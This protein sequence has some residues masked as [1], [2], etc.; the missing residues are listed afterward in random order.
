[1]ILALVFLYTIAFFLLW[2]QLPG[3]PL[4]TNNRSA[5]YHFT[6]I[7]QV[8]FGLHTSQAELYRQALAYWGERGELT[9]LQWRLIVLWAVSGLPALWLGW[10]TFKAS[11]TPG[12]T[13][14]QVKGRRLLEGDEGFDELKAVHDA[15]IARTGRSSFILAARGNYNPSQDKPDSKD[16]ITLSDDARRTHFLVLGGSRRGKGVTIKQMMQQHY[17]KVRRKKLIKLLI[18]DTPK[19]EYASMFKKKYMLQIAPD[20]KF[21]VKY[22][23]SK[24]LSLVQDWQQF[25]AGLIEVS[26]KDPFWGQAARGVVT[27]IGAFLIKECGEDWSFNNLAYFKD[28][29]APF[30]AHV[31]RKYYP[32]IQTIM[33]MGEAPLS[34]VLGNLTASLVW[35]N[36]LAR[37]WDGYEYKKE[38]HQLNAKMLRRDF[39]LDYMLDSMFPID[40]EQESV[41]DEV[42][43]HTKSMLT[44]LV[45][46][47]NKTKKVWTWKDLK[48]LL[49]MPFSAQSQIAKQ[50]LSSRQKDFI[51]PSHLPMY[52]VHIK[53]F[54]QWAEVWDKYENMPSFSLNEWVKDEN[55]SKK[56]VI[57]KPSGRFREQTV[58]L[59]RGMLFYMQGIINDKYFPEDKTAALPKREFYIVADEFQALGNLREFF[60][61]GMEM[62]ASKGVTLLLACQDFSQLQAIY[63][64]EWLNFLKTNTGNIIIA[65]MNQG[66][67]A[68]MV[69]TQLLG[70]KSIVKEHVTHSEG[71]DGKST[72]STFQ[73]HNDE[74]VLTPDEINSKFGPKIIKGRTIIQYLYLPGNLPNAYVLT[75]SINNYP[76]YYTP[77]PAD[78]MSGKM[79]QPMPY[80]R[81]GIERA[82]KCATVMGYPELSIL[83]E[84]DLKM[85]SIN[86]D[87]IIYDAASEMTDEDL[88]FDNQLEF[89]KI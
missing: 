2:N 63:G 38:I 70:K 56:I 17:Q 69:S 60:G 4:P 67:S 22:A 85:L 81:Q 64:D 40:I 11:M 7:L 15:E 47:L 77:E 23:I 62:F 68:E 55:P 88:T 73:Q 43:N 8:T 46:H 34:S 1:M 74:L 28:M 78:W 86:P 39:W 5:T 36:D 26:E 25:A 13:E 33:S 35:V 59:I 44:G 72:S 14:K 75:S 45:K 29:P 27:G 53:P 65:G 71:K 82:L 20:E 18:I 9:R 50:E 87:D 83:P 16:V 10:K 32:E 37:I 84:L 66:D 80:T 49:E 52:A 12:K 3:L 89:A 54:L 58:S 57:V 24:D 76:N 41:L 61:P 51:D 21:S 79:E 42:F 6:S 31:L 19:G 48:S 30:L